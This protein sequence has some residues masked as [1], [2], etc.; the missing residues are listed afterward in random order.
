LGK[1]KGKSAK[2]VVDGETIKR[3]GEPLVSKEREV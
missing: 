2:R 1:E 3:G